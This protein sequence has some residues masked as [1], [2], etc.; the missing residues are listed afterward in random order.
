MHSHT[1]A[2]THTHTHTHNTYTCTYT[3]TYTSTHSHS[4]IHKHTPT[5]PHTHIYTHIRTTPHPHT[6]YTCTPSHTNSLQPAAVAS[7]PSSLLCLSP[8]SPPSGLAY[9][10]S[11][12]CSV[13][14]PPHLFFSPLAHYE[15][16][17]EESEGWGG[18]DRGEGGRE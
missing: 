10:A 18:E 7:S 12:F 2:H 6:P 13:C 9:A 15:P 5:H 16:R 14:S 1:H 8:P 4:H 3:H 17:R 11:G